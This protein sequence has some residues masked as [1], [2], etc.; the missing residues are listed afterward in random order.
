MDAES[1]Y[2]YLDKGRVTL[3]EGYFNNSLGL[4]AQRPGELW[5]TPS[6]WFD[7]GPGV[8][9]EWEKENYE[10]LLDSDGGI[11]HWRACN[12]ECQPWSP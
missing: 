7:M 10:M 4:E 12:P 6:W 5:S 1:C 11:F 8:N 9:S 3:Y 2:V